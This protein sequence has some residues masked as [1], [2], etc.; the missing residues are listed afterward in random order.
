M[1]QNPPELKD[2]NLTKLIKILLVE[3]NTTG[4]LDN[5]KVQDI[6][7]AVIIQH[8]LKKEHVEEITIQLKE[9]HADLKQ[10]KK[11]IEKQQQHF[12]QINKKENSH[13]CY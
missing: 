7:R 2:S 6:V 12:E 4:E 8:K 9:A 10:L 1:N 3:F 11:D 5:H 13:T